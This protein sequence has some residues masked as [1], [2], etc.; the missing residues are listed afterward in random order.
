MRMV[1]GIYANNGQVNATLGNA[2]ESCLRTAFDAAGNFALNKDLLAQLSC[3]ID[4]NR[5]F[6]ICANADIAGVGVR[7]A[8]YLNAFM[9]ASLVAFCPQESPAAGKGSISLSSAGE[10]RLTTNSAWSATILTAAMVIPAIIQKSQQ[11]LTLYHATLVLNFA[12]FSSIAS[13]AVVSIH[14][15]NPHELI[16]HLFHRRLPFAPSGKKPPPENFVHMHH[17]QS[18]QNCYTASPVVKVLESAGG[19]ELCSRA[20]SSPKCVFVALARITCR[21]YFLRSAC[22]GGGLHICSHP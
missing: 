19:P 9:T 20:L 4:S 6:G 15:S 11:T 8:F 18:L 10:R 16:T 17:H 3:S 7:T 21:S 5:C 22:S 1:G 2:L 13:L 12:T 14:S